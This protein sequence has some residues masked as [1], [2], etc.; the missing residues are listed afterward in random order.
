MMTIKDPE[1]KKNYN[2]AVS[3]KR[4]S[5]IIIKP[6]EEDASTEATKRN[7]K[8]KIDVLK[9]GVGITKM[10]K[11]TKEA[12]VVGCENKSQVERLKEKVTKDLGKY[13]I[14]VPKKKKLRLKD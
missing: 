14:Q 6:R 8:N 13:V 10:K 3:N 12:V 9:L 4:E 5:V 7:I 11:M 1:K 2:K